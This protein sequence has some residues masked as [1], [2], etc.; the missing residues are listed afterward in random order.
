MTEIRLTGRLVCA[1]EAEAAVVTALLPE[2][3]ALTLAEPGCL[4]FDV[5][6]TADPLVWTVAERFTDEQAFRAH[7]ARVSAGDWGRRTATV[8]RQYEVRGLPE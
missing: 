3:R 2:H 6:A 4:S 5:V 8:E 1:T 7:Q